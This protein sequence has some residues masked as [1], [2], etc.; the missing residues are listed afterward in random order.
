[1]SSE[2]ATPTGASGDSSVIPP[3]LAFAETPAED[4][5]T[6]LPADQTV[7]HILGTR[8]SE[9]INAALESPDP[10][11]GL[12]NAVETIADELSRHSAAEPAPDETV[13]PEEEIVGAIETLVRVALEMDDPVA[14][15][16]EGAESL[17][18]A[19]A[20]RDA[21][22]QARLAAAREQHIDEQTAYR[23]ARLHRVSELIDVGYGVDAAISI[24][25]ANEAEIRARALA[26]G[27]SPMEAI[28][29][30]A[31]RNGY[32][33]IHPSLEGSPA[34]RRADRT[35]RQSPVAA[36]AQL[37]EEAFAEATKGDRWQRLMQP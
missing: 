8:L 35:D 25:N 10:V 19:L 27:R 31:V 14:A 18:E 5:D 13:G 12:D 32:R 26:M 2:H 24:T 21:M 9:E 16:E 7:E 30:Y 11:A 37:S 3:T 6:E 23:Y 4:V 17:A 33:G 29:Q 15:L 1:M 28:Y 22:A 36:L 34:P 20:E